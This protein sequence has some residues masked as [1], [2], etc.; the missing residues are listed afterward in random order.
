MLLPVK[1]RDMPPPDQKSTRNRL[2]AALPPDDFALL[3]PRLERVDLSLREVLAEPNQPMPFAYF[4]EEGIASILIGPERTTG[5][6]IGNIGPEGLVGTSLVLGVD[7]TPHFTFIQVPGEGWRIAAEDLRAA[8]DNSPSLQAF[9]LRYVQTF[10]VQLAGTAYANADFTLEERMARW[11]LMSSDRS[12]SDEIPLTHEFL[13]LMLA[14]RRPGVT[15]TMHIL[16]GEHMIRA[17]RGTITI[18]DRKKLEARAGGSYGMPEA[19]YE[20]L[21]RAEPAHADAPADAP[22]VVRFPGRTAAGGVRNR[23]TGE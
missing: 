7:R 10:V 18:L 16:E 5:V 22:G 21:M 2:L 12:G 19:E 4:I 8:L 23:S 14:V 3:R 9:L 11:L 13:S 1:G 15:T 20:R 17:R 6:E